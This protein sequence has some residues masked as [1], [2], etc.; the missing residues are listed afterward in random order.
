M[1]I[2]SDVHTDAAYGGRFTGEVSLAMLATSDEVL[3][4]AQPD[5]PD[6]ARVSFRDGAVTCWHEH[7]GGQYLW[8]VSGSAVVGT[9]ADGPHTLEPG[10]LVVCPPN[11]KHWHG[12]DYGSDAIL[13]TITYGTTVWTDRA[14]ER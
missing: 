1:R 7:P 10:A 14:P 13:L 8:V 4:P 2:V 3:P 6:I 11:E 12:A 5:R 9:E